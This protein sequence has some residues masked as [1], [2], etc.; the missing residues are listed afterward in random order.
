MQT[1]SVQRYKLGMWMES[2]NGNWDLFWKIIKRNEPLRHA[3]S[4]TICL[5]PF[6]SGR[7]APRS[8]RPFIHDA[9]F[10][11]WL[12]VGNWSLFDFLGKFGRFSKHFV[13]QSASARIIYQ[14]VCWRRLRATHNHLENYLKMCESCKIAT[15]FCEFSTF[16]LADFWAQNINSAF[17]QRVRND[18][19]GLKFVKILCRE[20]NRVTL[21]EVIGPPL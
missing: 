11:C 2:V 12:S 21:I 3:L 9:Q 18:G 7:S 13:I 4:H 1:E 19:T 5:F 10:R 15:K 8:W 20:I 14:K 16:Y 17:I 6:T